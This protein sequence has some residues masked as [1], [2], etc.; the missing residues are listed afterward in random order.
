M[1][2]IFL[3]SAVLLLSLPGLAACGASDGGQD[4]AG[5][6]GDV[7][8]AGRTPDAV[9]VQ[10]CFTSVTDVAV[11]VQASVVSS[12]AAWPSLDGLPGTAH[13]SRSGTQLTIDFEGG[14]VFVGTI[15]DGGAISL[16][17]IHQHPWPDGCEYAATE[18]LVGTIDATCSM[19]LSYAYAESVA[20]SDGDCSGISESCPAS[21]EVSLT[22]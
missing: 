1:Q 6:V 7:P 19:S 10:G 20:V 21:S 2:T 13:I 4:D 15:D 22:L 12:C 14:V 17:Y 8:D 9:G 3:L 18:T 11:S 16:T 5:S